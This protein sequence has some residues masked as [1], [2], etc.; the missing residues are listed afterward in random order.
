MRICRPGTIIGPQQHFMED[1][2][3]QMWHDGDV[4]RSKVQRSLG[5]AGSEGEEG[6]RTEGAERIG[7]KIGSLGLGDERVV[8]RPGQSEELRARRA[9]AERK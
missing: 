5:Q 7:E 9:Q 2:Q 6:E 4:M 3:E 1:V 8:G